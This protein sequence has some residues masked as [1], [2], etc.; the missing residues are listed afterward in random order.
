MARYNF[1]SNSWQTLEC[2]H[3]GENKLDMSCFLRKIDLLLIS[4]A[5][6]KC[7]SLQT[8]SVVT[9]EIPLQKQ[10]ITKKKKSK[11]IYFL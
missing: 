9:S 7:K 6:S 10:F 8:P 11:I 5:L 3:T 2:C 4:G 1:L